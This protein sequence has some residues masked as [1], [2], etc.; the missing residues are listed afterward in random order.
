MIYVTLNQIRAS[1]PCSEGYAAILRFTGKSNPDDEPIALA[2]IVGGVGLE[3]A[4]WTITFS[5]EGARPVWV[6]FV[7]WLLDE[8]QA[9]VCP[10]NTDYLNASL[11]A[12]AE[13]IQQI[14][15]SDNVDGERA[16]YARAIAYGL[17]ALS[18]PTDKLTAL[19]RM[20]TALVRILERT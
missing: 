3:Y 12:A 2:A 14:I 6:E 8:L 10:G 1:K 19:T 7:A 15:A 20:Q 9:S 18:M 5:W 4:L 11:L 13:V 17:G 16:N